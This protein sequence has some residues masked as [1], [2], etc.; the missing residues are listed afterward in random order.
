MAANAL[1]SG[2]SP[3]ATKAVL[4]TDAK[5]WWILAILGIAQLM[6]VLDT[7]VM[8]IALPEAQKDLGFSAG[9]RQ[10]VVTGYALAF[11]SLLLFGGR[12][13]DIFGRRNAFIAGLVGFATASA[14]G[15]AA[16]NFDMLVGARVGQGV[17]AA[18]LAPAALSLLTVT[19]TEQ[20]DRAKAFGVFSAIMAMGAAVGLLLG[21]AVTEFASWRW[22]LYINLAFA[23]VALAGAVLLLPRHV[24]HQ[25]R[26]LD[27]P[28]TVTV[29]AGLFSIVYGFSRANSHGWS[30]G[31]TIGFL[32]VG[33]V[34][35][36]VFARL[37]T[38]V[39]N[40]L[41]PL[42]VVLNRSRA[43]SYLSVFTVSIAMFAIF[44]FISYYLQLIL[45]YSPLKS[46][47]AF[48]P[49]VAAIVLTATTTPAVVL[50]RLGV[51][52]T[53]GAGFLIS[54]IG[55]ALLTQITVDSSYIG[56]VLPGLIVLGC[57]Y[58]AVTSV[59]LQGATTAVHPDDTGVASAMVNTSQQI[60]GSIGTAL[61]STIAATAATNYLAGKT[62]SQVVL[63]H[64][65]VE[66]YSTVFWWVSGIVLIGG[67]IVTALRPNALPAV[68]EGEPVAAR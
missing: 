2:T 58:G 56:H 48:L 40:P 64:A 14:I 10:W 5:R 44:L 50:P 24:A 8:N 57:G 19:F 36:V 27:V 51:K 39:V 52:A 67:L 30:N 23:G 66:S 59:S 47:I 34:L 54:A 46:G 33:V 18:L 6:V 61:L 1:G 49:M 62:P 16:Q 65:Q 21:G 9:D 28:G 60:G 45:G 12:I 11:G 38:Q 37:Q 43:G 68:A 63:A 22:A 53:V 7:T 20:S 26:V 31:A 41:L 17:F 35:L 15:G 25:K 55:M 13:G 29:T 3:H 32:V 42:R 4:G